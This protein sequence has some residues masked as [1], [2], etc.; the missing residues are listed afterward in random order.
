MSSNLTGRR[1][2][3]KE[4]AGATVVLPFASN[5][6]IASADLT[7]NDAI[8]IILK[9][10]PQAPF[11]DTVDTVKCG[12]PTRKLTGIVTTFLAT[13]DVIRRAAELGANL[14]ITHEPTFYNHRDETDW[15]GSDAVYAAKKR[16]LDEKGIV[17]WRFHDY[18]HAAR[19][20]GILTGVLKKLGWQPTGQGNL[21]TIPATPLRDLALSVKQ[22]FASPSVRFVGNPDQLCRTVG[23]LPGASGGR[24]QIMLLSR[25][26]S[27]A[28]VCGE[29]AEWETSEY[30]RDAV[31]AGQA[32]GLI[33][34]G[35]VPSE[36]PGMEYLVE[37]LKP[38]LPN[39]DIT[40]VP[41]R[42][43]FVYV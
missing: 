20:D 10:I 7:I 5:A 1:T 14:I 8:G 43:P 29:I 4:M 28:L 23:L 25:E 13:Y 30:V 18:W 6:A 3:L 31:A 33:I 12:D 27:D 9:S 40:H 36:E 21:F 37:W 38:K 19:P 34:V 16:L 41:A 11:R 42:S 22:K 39:V 2:F 15:L 26:P 24:P 35:H 17:V 32:K